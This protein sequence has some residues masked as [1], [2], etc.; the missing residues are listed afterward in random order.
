MCSSAQRCH[1]LMTAAT[2]S[3][4]SLHLRTKGVVQ[5]RNDYSCCPLAVLQNESIMH[6]DTSLKSLRLL[7]IIGQ[8][9]LALVAAVGHGSSEFSE[10]VVVSSQVLNT[11]CTD[12]SRRHEGC[13]PE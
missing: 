12:G 1:D 3:Y 7:Y 9:L 4:D 2:A 11:E 10:L 13:I 5:G 8:L 6:A